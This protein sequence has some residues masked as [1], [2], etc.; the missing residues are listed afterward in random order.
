MQYLQVKKLHKS[1]TDRP[2][3]DG[4]DFSIVKGQKVA[5]VAKNWAGKST[6]L[7][8][9]MGKTQ[10]DDWNFTFHKDIRVGFLT[11]L[12]DIPEDMT[13]LDALFAYDSEIGQLIR[14]Y[15]AALMETEQNPDDSG[16][17]QIRIQELLAKIE[18]LD[19]REYEVKVKT[20]IS[21]LQLTAYL[22][23][24]IWS[25]SGGEAKRVAL[26][27][28]LMEDPHFLVL[29][30]PTNHLD[31]EM[32]EWLEK[33]LKRS[34]L[35][36]LIVTHDRYFLERVCTD[37]YELEKG[38]LH[39]YPGNYE[40]YL[41]KKAEREEQESTSL[42]H[43]KQLYKQELYRVRKAPRARGKKS[44]G[45]TKEFTALEEEYKGRKW[46]ALKESVK[47][48]I[49]IENRRLGTKVLKVHG[50][51][52]AYGDKIIVKSFKHDFM[53]GERVGIIGKNGVGKSS[54]VNLLAGRELPDNW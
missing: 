25:L 27:K 21:Q 54:F 32:I 31:L 14:N 9:L 26:A 28:V 8:I 20:I 5:L 51:Q 53:Q 18:E 45:R 6:L 50:L 37:I 34:D 1:Y 12:S 44:V 10:Q 29:D 16:L 22:N 30:E 49:S 23:Q 41:T 2:L 24:T 35:T 52:K 46:T 42:H 11:Q 13:V 15:E 47:L 38:K 39:M 17:R 19:A 33:Y 3:L 7:R 43:M 4:V 40:K 36:L 48:E